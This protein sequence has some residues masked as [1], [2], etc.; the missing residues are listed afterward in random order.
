MIL[1]CAG[2]ACP[3]A[4]VSRSVDCGSQDTVLECRVVAY[5]GRCQVMR[6]ALKNLQHRVEV[7]VAILDDNLERSEQFGGD[8]LEIF[9]GQRCQG[10][11]NGGCIQ[12]AVAIRN[13]VAGQVIAPPKPL[14]T[15]DFHHR[16]N[17]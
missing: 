11:L 3:H 6:Y 15:I 13:C 2:G 4:A 17:V 16:L 9:A 5:H 10:Y 7:L 8:Q 14:R 1:W 12:C